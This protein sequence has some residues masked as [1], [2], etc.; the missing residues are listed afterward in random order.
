[1]QSSRRFEEVITDALEANEII[2]PVHL[3]IGQEAIAAG[4][5]NLLRKDDYFLG[6]HRAHGPYI[7]KGGSLDSLAS[8]IFARE[9]GCSGRRGG[10]MHL[11]NPDIGVLGTVPIVGAAIPLATVSMGF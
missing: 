3:Y 7:A 2:G 4:V 9:N 5:I 10:S 1:M 8:E 11:T 6:G